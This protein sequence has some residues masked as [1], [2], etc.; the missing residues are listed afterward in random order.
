MN[1]FGNARFQREEYS[2]TRAEALEVLKKMHSQMT[3]TMNLNASIGARHDL[4]DTVI[5]ARLDGCKEDQ[6]MR[7]AIE[8]LMRLE[9]PVQF[10]L[11]VV[12]PASVAGRFVAGVTALGLGL[13]FVIH[14]LGFGWQWQSFAGLDADSNKLVGAILCLAGVWMLTKVRFW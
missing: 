2:I 10:G 3:V 12:L 14:G 5:T 4:E 13:W 8:H 1:K 9:T 6:A 7:L 11:H